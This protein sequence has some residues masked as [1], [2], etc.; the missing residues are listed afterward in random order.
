LDA[1]RSELLAQAGLGEACD[2]DHALAGAPRE[3]RERRAHLAADAEHH[4][5]VDAAEIRLQLGARARHELL[6]LVDAGEARRHV[7][8]LVN[9]NRAP[10]PAISP[11][12][13]DPIRCR[14]GWRARHR[15][16]R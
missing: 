12:W 8:H 15:S 16:R 9:Y 11:P 4:D 3:A 6:E 10:C 5:L 7:N 1:P 14:I 2:A 13:S